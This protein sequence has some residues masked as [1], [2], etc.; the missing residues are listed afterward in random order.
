MALN[1]WKLAGKP[2]SYNPLP[3]GITENITLGIG[4]FLIRVKARSASG[5]YLKSKLNSQGLYP[6]NQLLSPISTTYEFA[7]DNTVAQPIYIYDV[8][9]KGDIIIDSIELVNKALPKLTINGIDGFQSGKWNI[10]PDAKVIDDDTLELNP[11]TTYRASLLDINVFPSTTY[12]IRFECEGIGQLVVQDRGDSSY[13]T[14]GLAKDTAFTFTTKASTTMIR[15]WVQNTTQ[16]SRVVFKRL[17]LN[18]GSIPAPYSKKTGE[19]MV[20]PVV[21]KN[22]FTTQKMSEFTSKGFITVDDTTNQVTINALGH[23]LAQRFDG[24]DSKTVTFSWKVKKG[25]A[26]SVG[27]SAHNLTLGVDIVPTTRYETRIG[28]DWTTIN[29]TFTVPT[30]AKT[31]YVYPIRDGGSLGTVFL[32][33]F[34]LEINSVPTAYEPYAVQV[35]KKPMRYVPK[36]NLLPNEPGFWANSGANL[37]YTPTLIA[38]KPNTTYVFKVA[39]GFTI[40]FNYKDINKAQLGWVAYQ[41]SITHTTG[42]STYYVEVFIQKSPITAISPSDMV[43]IFAQIEEGSTATPYENYQLVL[44]KARTGLNMNGLT[45]RVQLPSMLMDAIEIECLIDVTQP[46]TTQWKRV[47]DLD[48]T[49][50]YFK[51]AAN[52]S[53]SLF[54]AFTIASGGLIAGQR[55]KVL[56]SKSAP[57]N[58]AIRLFS[59]GTGDYTKG[60]IYKVTCYLAGQVVAQYDFENPSNLVADKLI[61]NAKNL[62]PSF[63]D[64]RWS[65]HSN[66]RVL[67]RDVGRLDA[68]GGSQLSEIR[69]PCRENTS[70]LAKIQMNADRFFFGFLDAN[71]VQMSV[72][73]FSN[74]NANYFQTPNGTQKL[75]I[76]LYNSTINAGSFDFIKPSLYQLDGKEATLYGGRN[77]NIKPAKRLL[78]AKR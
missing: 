17:M 42:A 10:S 55:S 25:T 72:V 22:L 64:A 43:N 75:R 33:D 35:N 56:L 78:Y 58:G 62:I 4:S 77:P 74:N 51:N 19:R 31:I 27:Y 18:L 57:F 32:K 16:L 60:T 5:A 69:I 1:L 36:K 61:P 29:F 44:P 38:V 6:F 52:S 63:E 65:L 13:Y 67:G 54:G 48:G 49:D 68:S 66:F 45:D 20:M 70:Y 34:Q 12:T 3:T 71:D 23:N 50:V 47:V 24:L 73:Y 9:S 2:T 37:I 41:N 26:T 15:I 53:F 40:G 76:V 39:T 14:G 21:K 59:S 28:N 8:N 7:V 11:T 30:T 46:N